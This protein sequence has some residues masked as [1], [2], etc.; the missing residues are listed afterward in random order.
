VLIGTALWLDHASPRPTRV[1]TLAISIAAVLALVVPYSHLYALSPATETWA[2]TVP[3]FLTRKLPRGADDVQLLIVSGICAAVFVFAFVRP[4]VAAAAI[5]ILIVLYFAAIQTV[6]IH[7]VGKAAANYRAIPSLGADAN[8]LD[9]AVPSGSTVGFLLGTALG[10][11][12]DRLITW[13]TG[14]FNRTQFTTAQWGTDISV[15]TLTGGVTAPGGTPTSLPTFVIT[16]AS[17]LLEGRVIADRGALVLEE[18]R[19]PYTLELQTSGIYPDTWTS[20]RGA[21]N[22]YSA[23]DATSIHVHIDREG[24]PTGVPLSTVR[25]STGTINVAPDGTTEI[26]P[27]TATKTGT[28]SQTEAMDFN[29]PIPRSPFRVEIDFEQSFRRS[30]FGQDDTRDLGGRVVVT[31]SGRVISR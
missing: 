6:V 1:A 3:E 7:T 28:I 9:T 17:F 25:V 20:P 31:L 18:P 16:P 8:W 23:T 26:S 5:P 27:V 12:V 22:Y 10:P 11:D 4:R 14:F 19:L 21:I 29:L 15:D 30:D 24:A 2:I 13:Q